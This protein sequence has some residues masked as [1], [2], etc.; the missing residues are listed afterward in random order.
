VALA[1][2]L[3]SLA[4]WGPCHSPDAVRGAQQAGG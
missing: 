3:T 4:A 1:T 2:E